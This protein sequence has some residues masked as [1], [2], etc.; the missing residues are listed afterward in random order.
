MFKYHCLNPIAKVGLDQLDQNYE[1]TEKQSEPD[2]N[3]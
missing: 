3:L 1:K 2:A